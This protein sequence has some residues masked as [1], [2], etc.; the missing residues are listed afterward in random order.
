LLNYL[1]CLNTQN[2]QTLADEI[3]DGA[4]DMCN[5]VSPDDMTVLVCRVYAL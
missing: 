5:G 4:I 3:L 1:T 2:P